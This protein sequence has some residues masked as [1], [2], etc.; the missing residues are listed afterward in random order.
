[1]GMISFRDV[2]TKKP[3]RP[4]SEPIQKQT[5]AAV[6]S[7]TPAVEAKPIEDKAEEK[8]APRQ[9]GGKTSFAAPEKDSSK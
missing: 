1:M 8:P 5:T 9:R 6:S 3:I 4:Q 7:Q 2:D